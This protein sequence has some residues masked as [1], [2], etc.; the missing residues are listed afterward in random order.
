MSIAAGFTLAV[1]E[2]QPAPPFLRPASRKDSLPGKISKPDLAK[3]SRKVLVLFQSPEL[4]F[5]PAIAVGYF[6]S[7]RST[8]PVVM[9]T[10]ATGGMW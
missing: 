4:S 8:R 1:A 10:T 9:P 2:M 6:F 5:M 7:S 3:A